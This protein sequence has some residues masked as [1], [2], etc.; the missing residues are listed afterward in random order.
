M[1]L[2]FPAVQK[3][4]P[5]A[6]SKSHFNFQSVGIGSFMFWL[7]QE[8]GG[9]DHWN[10]HFTFLCSLVW[11]LIDAWAMLGTDDLMSLLTSVG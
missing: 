5:P 2:H 10:K 7:C 4:G 6:V 1:S 3:N 8:M 11:P 9:Y